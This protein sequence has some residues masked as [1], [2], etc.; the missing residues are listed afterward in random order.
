MRT[1][2]LVVA[3]I[4]VTLG[5]AAVSQ[6]RAEMPFPDNLSCYE[7]EY[8]YARVRPNMKKVVL[9]VKDWVVTIKNSA[10]GNGEYD[11]VERV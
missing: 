9:S 10:F 5:L 11:V 6:A 1:K 4:M 3:L 8:E 2:K 7:Y